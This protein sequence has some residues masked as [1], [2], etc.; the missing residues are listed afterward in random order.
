MATSLERTRILRRCG[1][2]YAG[3][4]GSTCPADVHTGALTGDEIARHITQDLR[5][6]LD[7]EHDTDNYYPSVMCF[8]APLQETTSDTRGTQRWKQDG[9]FSLV[10]GHTPW[11]VGMDVGSRLW[12]GGKTL[13]DAYTTKFGLKTI[14]MGIDPS[15][16]NAHQFIRNGTVNNSIVL[17]G[18]YRCYS[19]FTESHFDLIP[20][21]GHFGPDALPGDA[22][23]RRGEAINAQDARSALVGVDAM[24]ES[25]KAYHRMTPRI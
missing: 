14:S 21:Q 17:Q 13:F 6:R 18:P 25:T 19:P 1:C 16:M 7:F 5:D 12:P 24:M 4:S 23:W 9:A 11:D 10:N 22:R 20:G 15:S 3:N 8:A 2:Q